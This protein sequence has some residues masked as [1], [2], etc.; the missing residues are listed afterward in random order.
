VTIRTVEFRILGPL[1]VLA[2]DRR[3]P[4]E[5]PK[6][7]ALLA[8]LL[9]HANE[10]VPRERL[11]EELWSGRAPP[12]A[13]KVLQTYV[14]QLRR[15]LGPERIRTVR[16]S[17]ELRAEPGQ[18]DLH[19]F[20]ELVCRARSEAPS[21]AAQTFRAALA[22]WRGPA[23]AE[24]AQEP[25]AQP[26]AAHLEELRLAALEERIEADIALGGADELAPEL[27]RLVA[28]HPLRERL[29]CQ[30]MLVLYRAGRQADALAVYRETREVLVEALGIEP[31]A[32]L[33]R[34]ERAVLQQD[35]GLE[36]SPL[37]PVARGAEPQ[38]PRLP[39]PSSSFVGRK[40][41]LREIRAIVR[42]D[43][44][45]LLTLTGA[46]GSGKTRL[47]IEAIHGADSAPDALFVELAPIT[48]GSLVA[49]TIADDLG[50]RQRPGRTAKQA[51]IEYLRE[52]RM[53]L[54]L[55]NFEQVLAAATLLEELLAEA[56]DLRLVVTS[57]IALALPDERIFQVHPLE[58]PDPSLPRAPAEL[59]HTEAI[60][61]FV[62][63][64]RSARP[65]F[66]LSEANADAVAEIC[67]RLDGLPL[68]LELAA[69]RSNLLSPRTVLERLTDRLD[70]K[71]PPGSGLEKRHQTLRGAIEWSHGLLE[72][73]LQ[74]LFANLGVFV[75][76]LTVA[77]AEAVAGDLPVDVVDGVESLL[78][79]NL[80]T[81]ARTAGDEPRLGMLETIREYALERLAA[82]GDG[83]VVRRRHALYY[84]ALA[85][86][87]EPG[88]RGPQTGAWLERL[89]AE[90]ENIRAAM[91][92]A[93]TASEEELGLRIGTP[94][95][96]YWSFRNY[97]R[98][99]RGRLEELLECG[100]ASPA[101]RARAQGT[102]ASLAQV[103][104]D[105]ETVGRMVEASLPVLRRCGEH[106]WVVLSLGLLGTSAIA[107]GD[108]SR[109]A[110]HFDAEL[111]AA[112]E[113]GDPSAEYY[114]LAH[115]A[116]YLATTGQLDDAEQAFG[117]AVHRAKALGDLRSIAHWSMALAG[118]AL[119]RH[120]HARARSLLE[121][122]LAVYRGFGDTWGISHALSN[123]TYIALDAGENDRACRLL[124]E[125]LAADSA[126]DDHKPGLA[127]DLEMSARLAAA[128]GHL[129]RAVAIY[130]RAALLR[131]SV[132]VH[133]M[134][135][136]WPDPAPRMAELRSTVG[137]ADFEKAW[138]Q[139]RAM[140]VRQAIEEAIDETC[141]LEP[142]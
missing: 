86:A 71:A 100:E 49:R 121:E 22:L 141:E 93:L 114:A 2:G 34:L 94:L 84:A 11:I 10:A 103:Q 19:R 105:H 64:A 85:E 81:G 107:T 101:A 44:V 37:E 6:L 79:N 25:W 104:G 7:R 67:V 88:L 74:E 45:R 38:A 46:A 26:E 120:D 61:L 116:T 80:L 35:P 99:A 72:P 89:D 73:E 111:T 39:R 15:A 106:W 54:L 134:E 32:A 58:L 68:A 9:L 50:V 137:D 108:I 52:R 59:R 83:E 48:D 97:E 113:A 127:N 123:L 138:A 17:Y 66:E 122:C 139:G 82:R 16:S 13:A 109:A 126:T 5:A 8:I 133:A 124:S 14:S 56:R 95:W 18:V 21:E 57:R 92:W 102:I 132:G 29:R 28:H 136:W 55:D 12:S 47:A 62:D 24:H 142:A 118:L 78:R 31:G 110:V 115:T 30:L 70:L 41:E 76:G 75:G 4:L 96:R 33:R 23:L 53:L 43:D 135:V 77:G 63:R 1:E 125:S 129:E 51:L 119:I 131:E 20:H 128:Q 36:L 90:L 3:V 27:E 91:S 60:R 140:T 40:R 65:D 112:R 98:E 87:A 69:A 42:R 117:D 130:A